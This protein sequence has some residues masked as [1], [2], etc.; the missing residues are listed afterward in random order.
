MNK[1]QRVEMTARKW[2]KRLRALGLKPTSENRFTCFKEQAKPCSCFVCRPEKYSR[3]V[4]H[5]EWQH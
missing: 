1:R 4:K 3:K 2:A 5:K